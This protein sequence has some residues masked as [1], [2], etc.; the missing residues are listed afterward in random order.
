MFKMVSSHEMIHSEQRVSL[1]NNSYKHMKKIS[2]LL[3]FILATQ[4]V[5]AQWF[6]KEK[7]MNDANGGKGTMDK[8]LLNWGYFFGLNSYDFKFEYEL[9]NFLTSF[10][11]RG[12]R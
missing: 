11:G 12:K 5:S 4:A 10:L 6:T 9:T 1:K 2:I 3:L 8:N 7:I